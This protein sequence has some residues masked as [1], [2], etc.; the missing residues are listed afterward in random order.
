MGREP[1]LPGGR[2]GKALGER[3]PTQPCTSARQPQQP[4]GLDGAGP[5]LPGGLWGEG[6]PGGRG[7]WHSTHTLA[8]VLH[9]SAGG[10][11][12]ENGEIA[13]LFA[14][15]SAGVWSGRRAAKV[16]RVCLPLL[17]HS[18]PPLPP[19]LLY[20]PPS[21]TSLP[22]SLSLPPFLPHSLPPSLPPSH[23]TAGWSS[24]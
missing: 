11:T 6:G 17:S 2:R 15:V 21:F 18:F 24:E 16:C 10:D 3:D 12:Q 22:P 23:P 20:L 1:R 4:R 13:F 5:G 14:A 7:V 8:G 9:D 19:S